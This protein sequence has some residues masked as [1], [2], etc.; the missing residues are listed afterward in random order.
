MERCWHG[1][2]SR[3]GQC[4]GEGRYGNPEYRGDP[5]RPG[6]NATVTFMRAARWCV[7]HQHPDDRLLEPADE[8]TMP[9]QDVS[10]ADRD[11]P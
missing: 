10:P 9:Q 3:A 4:L 6:L 5:D 8:A 1:K 11:A 7:A 2:F